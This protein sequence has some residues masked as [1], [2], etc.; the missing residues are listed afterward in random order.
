MNPYQQLVRPNIARLQA[1]SSAR[2]EFDG[3][4]EVWLDANEN[5]FPSDWN[6]Y[7]DPHQRS[8]KGRIATQKGVDPSSIFVGNGSDEAIDLLVRIFCRPGLDHIITLPP[9]Y[10]MYRVAADLNDV[11]QV[12]IPLDSSFQPDV[13]GI[14][15]AQT[16]RSKL[17]FLCSPNNPT[18]NRMEAE[19]VHS[20]LQNF[21]GIVVIDEAYIDFAQ[22]ESWVQQLDQYPNLVILQ[23]F[24]KA[25]GL[26]GLR[27]GLAFSQPWINDL[28]RRTKPPYN[29]N[30]YSQQMALNALTNSTQTKAAVQT[31]VDE[32]ARLEQVLPSL[33]G[34]CQC[35]PS[36]ANFLL[37]RCE[38]ARAL[39]DFLLQKGIVVRDRSRLQGCE[40]CLR[41]SIGTPEENQRLI[42]AIQSFYPNT[43]SH[44]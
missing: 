16:D 35:F 25:W 29:V 38:Q 39:Y 2:D 43:N 9:T 19:K 8:L 23:T 1:Y 42:S 7:P 22:D 3:Q 40:D 24:S 28:F 20:L 13:Q 15:E 5:P 34:I 27:L 32:R 30:A 17:L 31:L 12:E 4:A 26:A 6:R 21:R 33:A 18:G 41:F 10:G 37:V 36:E 11:G 44:E 14:L